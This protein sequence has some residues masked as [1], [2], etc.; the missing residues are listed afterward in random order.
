MPS[1]AFHFNASDKQAYAARLLRKAFVRGARTH[2]LLDSG[3]ASRLDGELWVRV[4][5][6]FLPHCLDDSPA[7]IL[8]RSPIVLGPSVMQVQPH[9][10]VLVNLSDVLPDSGLIGRYER[11]IEVVSTSAKDRELARERWRWYRESGM[12]PERYDL[13]ASDTAAHQ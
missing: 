3:L 6:D 4:A 10:Q 8:R 7:S 2:V 11:I 13:G 12:E 9:A 1:V 5:G